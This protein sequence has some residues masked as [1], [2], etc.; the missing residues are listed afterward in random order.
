[1]LPEY[2]RARLIILRDL[3]WTIPPFRD[4]SRKRGLQSFACT[5]NFQ[6][7]NARRQG[8]QLGQ[9]APRAADTHIGCRAWQN[10]F[11]AALWWLATRSGT[12]CLDRALQSGAAPPTLRSQRLAYR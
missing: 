9:P 4:R 1:M 7:H 6:V 10:G 3:A 2:R 5:R 8:R 11:V 12:A